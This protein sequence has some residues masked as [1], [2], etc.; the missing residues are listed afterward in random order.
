MADQIPCPECR[1]ANP[2]ENR[3]CGWC[4]ASLGTSTDLMARREGRL[5]A[6]GHALPVKPGPIGTAL[7]VGLGTLIVR[8][9]MSWLRHRFKADDRSSALSTREHDTALSEY[10]LGQGIE[11]ILIQELG[12][13]HQ[14][15][16]IAWQ[17]IRSVTVTEWTASSRRPAGRSRELWS[18]GGSRASSLSFERER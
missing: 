17:A 10:Y 18:S 1:H 9:G 5:T 2:P 4:G 12:E 7:A 11:K 3:F 15:R 14:G 8:A 16:N 13:A 6:M